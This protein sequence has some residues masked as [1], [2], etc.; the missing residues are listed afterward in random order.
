MSIEDCFDQDDWA[1]WTSLTGKTSIQIVGDDLLVTNPK[2]IKVRTE[3]RSALRPGNE[4]T[5]VA[6]E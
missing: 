5:D 6:W 4:V 2:R 1:A 3:D